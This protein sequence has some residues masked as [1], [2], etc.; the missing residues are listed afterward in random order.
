MYD[1]ARWVAPFDR[2][3]SRAAG[4]SKRRAG[5]RYQVRVHHSPH[6][7]ARLRPR[8]RIHDSESAARTTI[9]AHLHPPQSPTPSALHHTHLPLR[10]PT[11][12]TT[13]MSTPSPIGS[14]SPSPD[15]ELPI[16]GLYNPTAAL[17]IAAHERS[18]VYTVD[19]TPVT[20]LVGAT[21]SGKTTQLPQF[22]HRAGFTAGGLAIAVTQPRRLA[23]TTVAARV[24]EE[25]GVTLGDEVGYSIRFEDVTSARTRIKYMTDGMLLREI[26]VDPLLTRYG[27]VMVD[28]AHERSI[29]TDIL[30]G[31]LKKIRRKRKDLRLV[32]SSATLQAERFK[33]FFEEGEETAKVKEA[34]G[35]EKEKEGEAKGKEVE[36]KGKE[37]A[38]EEDGPVARIVSIEGRCYPVDI[39]YLE[40]PTEDYVERALQTVFDIHLKEG[41]GDIL[42]F[43]TGRDEIE[44]AVAAI[45]ERSTTLHPRAPKLL[46]FPLYAGLPTDEQ[47]SI[48]SPAPP[49]SRKAIFATNIAEASVTI[50]GVAFVVDCGFVKLRAFDAATGIDALAA[51]PVSKAAA[52]QRAGRAG[53]TKPGKCF[54]LYTEKTYNEE[55]DEASI[56][57]IQRSNLAPVI[58]QLKALGIDNVVRFDYLT[59]PPAELMARALEL[60]Y[61]LGALDD[62]AKL[63]RPLGTRM[64][65]L[66]VPPMLAKILLHAVTTSCLPQILSIAAMTTAPP[67]FLQPTPHK[68]SPAASHKRLFT[69]TEGDHLT[70]LNIYT[71]F[72][73]LGK[74]SA[75]WAHQHSLNHRSLTRAVSIRSQL[76]R[77]LQRL[78]GPGHPALIDAPPATSQTKAQAT[79]KPKPT[80]VELQKCLVAGYFAH[81]A[82]MQPDGTY[83]LVAD[84]AR[85]LWVHPSSVM[86]N[87]AAEWVV[88]G[89]LVEMRGKVYM[90]DVTA[91]EKAW[92]VEGAGGYYQVNAPKRI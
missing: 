18:L 46:P 32:V 55:L 71:A 80:A 59:A 13:T 41:D 47:L 88:F 65:E 19:T 85:V 28:E 20:I 81:A 25:M 84:A 36:G 30:L 74:Q 53:R 37:T 63:T 86:F 21:G 67:I 3:A 78:H 76:F 7:R 83:R 49:H 58:L 61:A 70:L 89:E 91:V 22:L 54:R 31:V 6:P 5:P 90:R 42:I 87:R 14:R 77:H 10:P 15:T 73:T 57:E 17:P 24:A 68:S 16:T 69:V 12:T 51:A 27:V 62:Y 44:R 35:K 40:E 39:L 8:L 4:M 2:A 11:T 72:T 79:A 45:T 50:D 52:T 29:S 75:K 48:F 82:R 56:P 64:A 23:A 66:P 26:L 43:L 34:K 38:K 33:E 9:H 92:I 60:L 1:S